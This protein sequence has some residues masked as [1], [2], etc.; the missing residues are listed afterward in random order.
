MV[1]KYR[2]LP[3][4]RIA[5]WRARLESFPP[6]HEQKKG[7]CAIGEFVEGYGSIFYERDGG[8]SIK[9]GRTPK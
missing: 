3:P 1:S 4:P 2:G 6:L 5:W 8:L 7:R 9:A